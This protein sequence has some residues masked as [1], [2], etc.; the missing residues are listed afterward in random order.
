MTAND[1]VDMTPT[2]VTLGDLTLHPTRYEESLDSDNKP[3]ILMT[4]ILDSNDTLRLRER[5]ESNE[6]FEVTRHGVSD[7]PLVL[8]RDTALH[9][10][11]D[12]GTTKT[13]F[14]LCSPSVGSSSPSGRLG[15]L[16]NVMRL[17]IDER[18]R[19]NDLLRML[20]EK[21]V[22]SEADVAALVAK[23]DEDGRK[24]KYAVSEVRDADADWL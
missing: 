24:I 11:N 13:R 2:A 1:R 18:R 3:R 20:K 10:L 4:V 22:L 8:C 17:V 9:S 21:G 15:P 23:N 7:V 14:A 19:S 16:T 6:P 12:D 5:L